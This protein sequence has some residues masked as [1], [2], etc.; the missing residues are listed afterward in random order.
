MPAF[1]KIGDWDRFDEFV[2]AANDFEQIIKSLSRKSQM[3]IIELFAE[4]LGFEI[5]IVDTEK[6][7]G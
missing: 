5:T 7:D 2:T 3:R 1:V 6:A 4:K